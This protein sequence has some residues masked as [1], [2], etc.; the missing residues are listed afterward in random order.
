MNALS[1]LGNSYFNLKHFSDARRI[2][3]QMEE[4]YHGTAESEEA[5][6][7]AALSSEELG[8]YIPAAVTFKKFTAYYPNSKF[9]ESAYLASGFNYLKGGMDDL[10]LSIL[11][12]LLDLNPE[13]EKSLVALTVRATVFENKDRYVEALNELE[14]AENH[15]QSKKHLSLLLQSKGRLQPK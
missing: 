6:K 2:Y 1:L 7:R 15:K 3:F 13:S 9:L 8:D 10:T 11:Q 4:E 14:L 12:E 5:F